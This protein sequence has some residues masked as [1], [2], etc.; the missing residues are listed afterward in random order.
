[1]ASSGR[2]MIARRIAAVSLFAAVAA[3]LSGAA[4]ARPSG[5]DPRRELAAAFAEDDAPGIDR[6]AGIDPAPAVR[7]YLARVHA[8]DWSRFDL[9]EARWTNGEPVGG[10]MVGPVSGPATP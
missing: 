8:E 5:A 6:F 9:L 10:A 2:A 3:S 1:M 4:A 7:E